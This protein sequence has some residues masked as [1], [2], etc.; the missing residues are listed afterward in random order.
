MKLNVNKP[1]PAFRQL[2]QQGMEAERKINQASHDLLFL[3]EL[4]KTSRSIKRR[5]IKS[6][7]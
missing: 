5:I 3:I 4:S 2:A 1:A 7:I 6:I